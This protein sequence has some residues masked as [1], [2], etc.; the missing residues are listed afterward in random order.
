M[1]RKLTQQD[2]IDKSNTIHQ[3]K[4]DYSLIEY[5]NSHTKIIIICP[6]H[7]QFLQTPAD[8]IHKQAGCPSCANNN[9][10][11][12][13]LKKYGTKHPKQNQAVNNKQKQTNLERYGVEYIGQIPAGKEKRNQTNLERY[14]HVCSVQNTTI[15]DRIKQHNLEE[16]GV[17]YSIQRPD[18]IK[19]T[20]DTWLEKYGVDNPN[21]TNEIRDKINQTNLER[22][23]YHPKQTTSIQEKCKQTCLHKYGVDNI[24]KSTDIK[25]K[26]EQTNLERY[27][28]LI[29]SQSNQIKDKIKQTNLERY[30]VS[31]LFNCK[32]I[33]E[34]RKQTNLQIYGTE[35]HSQQH[36]VN[37]LPLLDDYDW[38]YD[39]YVVQRK[40]AI[41]IAKEL[42]VGSDTTIG[43]YLKKHEIKIRQHHWHSNQCI[44]WL[45]SIMKNNNIHI[46]HAMNG[47]EY[48]IPGTRYKAD[49]YCA[50][51]N[52][53]YEFHGDYWHG[54]PLIYESHYINQANYKSMGELYQ[55]TIEKEEKI[56]ELGYNLVVMWESDL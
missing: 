13:N 31:T 43:R 30:G 5:K 9:R 1:P 40:T 52:T 12:T 27:G 36:M 54:N 50:E 42:N 39:Q 24:F 55:K 17:E 25:G 23:G 38:L 3:N 45:E 11:N 14:G 53:I 51:T 6:I 47:G 8:H 2:I 21:K 41:Q 32:K 33:K 48:K 7:G 16:H 29:P 46:Q 4:Y 56:K 28:Y 15:Q 10:I 20:M 37:I 19:K 34:Q 44:Q 18:V 22:Y 49:G 35:Y 26:I